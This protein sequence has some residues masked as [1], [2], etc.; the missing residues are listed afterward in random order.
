ME[1]QNRRHAHDQ[2]HARSIVRALGVLDQTQQQEHIQKQRHEDSYK[3]NLFRERRQN[4][5]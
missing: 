5:I 2:K 3:S 1:T 4:K